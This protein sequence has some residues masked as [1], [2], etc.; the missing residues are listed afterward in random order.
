MSGEHDEEFVR[1]VADHSGRL[2]TAAWM[3]TGD[4]H[5]AEELVQEAME[6]VYLKWGRVRRGHPKAYARKILVNLHTDRWRKRRKEVLTDAVPDRVGEQES[7][8]VD[9]VRALQ[10]L[11]P[12]EREV[13]VLRHYLDQS[14]RATADA[15]GVRVGT[16]KA[17]GSR[18]LSRMR[19]LLD[20]D[21]SHATI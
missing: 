18:G 5:T 11:P 19:S 2:L 21:E 13:V 3:L 6:R 16:V 12:R 8:H 14:E 4:P 20:G 7:Q 15:L 17:S 1:F 10:S 9:L